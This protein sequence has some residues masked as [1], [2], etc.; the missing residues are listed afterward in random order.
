METRSYR[1]KQYGPDGSG[2]SEFLPQ[3]KEEN[4]SDGTRKYHPL[5]VGFI[6]ELFPPQRTS[7]GAAEKATVLKVKELG[8]E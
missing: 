3:S 1:Y 2:G 5:T 6:A 8:R 4:W 7:L